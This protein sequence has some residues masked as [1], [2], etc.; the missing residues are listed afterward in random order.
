MSVGAYFSISSLIIILILS[1]MFFSK[2]R[3][4]NSETKIY[5]LMLIVTI[6]GLSLEII[7]CVWFNNGANLN[8]IF[9]KLVSKL[10]S[11]YYV[12]W[13]GLFVIYMINI[14][15][16]KKHIKNI[17]VFLLA[18]VF[19]L[20]L[21]LPIS[22][23]VSNRGVL[24]VGPSIYFTYIM[25]FIFTIVDLYYCLKYR[26]KIV[27]SKFTPV[28]SLMLLG[29]L[30]IALSIFYPELFLIGY[31]YSLIVIIMYFT[32]ENPD[33]KMVAQLELAKNQAEKANRAKSDF[34]SSMSHE[35][36][37]PLNAIVG[38]SEDNLTYEDKLPAEV[39]ENSKDIQNASQTLL[40]IVGNILDVN[41]IESEKLEIINHP[42][43]FREEITK[44]CK[45]TTTRIGDKPITFKLQI[46]EDI[47]YELIGDKAHLKQV[48]NNLLSNAI[49]YTEKGTIT[50]NAKCINKNNMCNLMI[51]VQDTG[52]GIKAENINKLFTKFERL[53]VEKNSTTEGTGL[54]LA[55]TKSLVD[56]MGGKINVQ[57]QFGQGS[58]FVVQLSQKI[59]KLSRPITD[60]QIINTSKILNNK[61]TEITSRES[62]SINKTIS[63]VDYGNQKI[64]IVDD[65]KLNIKVAKKALSDFN[66]EIDECYDGQQCLDKI[67]SGNNYNLI[68]M[69]IMM[70]NMSGETTMSKLKE[71]SDFHTPVIALTADAVA[72]AKEKYIKEGFIDYISKPFN[73]EQIKE[74]LDKVINN[75]INN[76]NSENN[77]NKKYNDIPEELLDM[78]KPLSEI[79]IELAQ[80]CKQNEQ[81]NQSST[82]VAGRNNYKGNTEYL[83][84]NNI[85]IDTSL[86]LLGDI[87]MYNDTLNEFLDNSD[88]RLIK[89]KNYLKNED[90]KN[91]AIE[92]HALKSDSKYL[93][94]TKLAEISLEHELKSKENDFEFVK[95][96]YNQL[97]DEFNRIID[98]TKKYR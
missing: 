37:T 92:V 80:P 33:V 10:T 83:K 53:D 90:M 3:I 68:L 35:I 47:P 36:R 72:G 66:F 32:I 15:N 51:F 17:F 19:S 30:D 95:N 12:V 56:M 50:L 93:G 73:R 98:I 1:Y 55:I 7:T 87:E 22:Y 65:N 97:M 94:F 44:L 58:I 20:I 28:Y 27:N 40:E 82:I 48:V 6:I 34:L 13:S 63:K 26:K 23:D 60:T 41:K 16:S 8:S 9:Y 75:L 4:D 79:D 18:C 45:V 74:K 76:D 84:E 86:E 91:Y 77:I 52:K 42:Y 21:I 43:N 46:A 24:P 31:V 64:L 14:C 96:N 39:V 62:S 81:L 69:D 71:K 59:S 57:S 11:S 70:P 38:L 78:S 2:Q 88:E 89:L 29:G 49:K 25:C 5:G 67:N 54:G 85:D 61:E